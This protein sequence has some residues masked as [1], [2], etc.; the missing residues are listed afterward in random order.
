MSDF[1]LG[2]YLSHEVVLFIG[3][4]VTSAAIMSYTISCRPGEVI[5]I[6]CFVHVIL[7]WLGS[8]I[9]WLLFGPSGRLLG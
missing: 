6:F 1:M 5:I 4:T 2:V 8:L 7:L 9:F 3:S